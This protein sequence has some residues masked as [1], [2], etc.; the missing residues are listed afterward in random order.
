MS[1]FMFDDEDFDGTL[2][3][4]ISN[5]EESVNIIRKCNDDVYADEDNFYIGNMNDDDI[6]D[7]I[8][9]YV[10]GWRETHWNRSDWADYYGVDEDD[11][12]DAMDDDMR[13]YY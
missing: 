6:E 4:N 7:K 9:D 13:D 3:R 8:D 12:D 2:I 1:D 5:G 10:E 11:L